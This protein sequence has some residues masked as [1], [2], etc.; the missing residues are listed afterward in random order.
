MG[1]NYSHW[2]I[3]I[4]LNQSS[5]CSPLSRKNTITLCNIWAIF[6]RKQGRVTNQSVRIKIWQN[7]ENCK[8]I[9]VSTYSS[10]RS[11]RAYKKNFNWIFKF[12]CFSRYH[13]YIFEKNELDFLML[14]LK[15]NWL[16]PI[17]NPKNEKAKSSYAFSNCLFSFW[18]QFN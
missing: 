18:D 17:S 1:K 5:I 3:Q 6:A 2:T 14:N 13:A 8:I 11:Q 12:G 7:F 10:Y 9:L 4:C 16:A 15:L